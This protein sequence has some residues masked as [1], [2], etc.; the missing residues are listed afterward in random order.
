MTIAPLVAPIERKAYTIK[1]TC[2]VYSIGRTKL[3]A[4]FKAGRLRKVK[5]GGKSL[6]LVEDGD[7][8]WAS[9]TGQAA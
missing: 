8:W 2:A 1:E 5:L 3:Y 9:R 6:V 7:R 4:E